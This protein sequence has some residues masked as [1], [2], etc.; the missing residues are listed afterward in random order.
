MSTE[1]KEYIG[2]C[3][4]CMAQQAIPGKE[5]LQ[6]QN[7]VARPWSKVGADLCHLQGHTLLLLCD[8]YSNYIE[9]EKISK[10]TT[11]GVS[12]GLKIMFSLHGIPNKLVTDNG[13]QFSSADFTLFSKSWGFNHVTS[14]PH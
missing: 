4:I 7:F 10:I 14:S 5:L 12:K 11:Q 9:V 2:K 8:Y 13:P 3:D 6:Q 1:S